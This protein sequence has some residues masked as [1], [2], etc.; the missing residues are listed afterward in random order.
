MTKP[1][2]TPAGTGIEVE[3]PGRAFLDHERPDADLA[4]GHASDP[5]PGHA[6]A[7]TV[8]G[9]GDSP[10]EA[11]APMPLSWLAD[12]FVTGLVHCAC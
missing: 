3:D 11:V 8:A 12:A 10:V 6:D 1:L 7:E 2:T 4:Q 5:R 9:E